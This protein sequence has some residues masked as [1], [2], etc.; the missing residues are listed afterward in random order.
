MHARWEEF[1]RS[2]D[3]FNFHLMPTLHAGYV[4]F[5]TIKRNVLFLVETEQQ[6]DPAEVKV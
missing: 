4:N 3:T 6:R 1:R 2:Q 5:Y